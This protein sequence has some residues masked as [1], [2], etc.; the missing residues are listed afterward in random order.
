MILLLLIFLLASFSGT[1]NPVFIRF[2]TIEIPPL[3][4]SAIRFFIATLIMF[5]LWRKEKQIVA[6]KDLYKVL[7]YTANMILYVIGIQYTSL[8]MSGILYTFAPILT[9]FLAYFLLKEKVSKVQIVGLIS[10]L[11][12]VVIL[13][14]G[15]IETSDLF[16]YGTPLGNILLL[17]AVFTWGFYPVGARSLSKSYSTNTI[18]FYT[19]LITGLLSLVLVPIEWLIRPLV[20]SDLSHITIISIFGSASLGTV[21]FYLCYQWF[22]KH[23]SA[24]T[25]SFILYGSFMASVFYGAIFFQEHLTV[26]L[27]SGALLIIL[28]VFLATTY[29]QL[30]KRA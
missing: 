24:F 30:K 4:F 5:V 21:I 9:A 13:L 15:S 11:L 12:G 1:S 14:H 16:S 2:A 19:F 20:F 26:K 27:I 18:L 25:G 7:P 28:G 22:I 29:T 3:T 8:T 6:K 10:A 23:T 17:T